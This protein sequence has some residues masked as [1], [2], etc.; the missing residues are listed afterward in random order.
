MSPGPS[1]A[2]KPLSRRERARARANPASG[3][4]SGRDPLSSEATVSGVGLMSARTK[5][6]DP[7][8]LLVPTS[9]RDRTYAIAVPGSSLPN[10]LSGHGLHPSPWAERAP[11]H[12]Y[13]SE[14]ISQYQTLP[15]GKHKT[16]VPPAR[17]RTAQATVLEEVPE[18]DESSYERSRFSRDV[19][20]HLPLPREENNSKGGMGSDWRARP[21]PLSP[22]GGA[23]RERSP[24]KNSLD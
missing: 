17:T 1:A 14:S 9:P 12:D 3:G 20:P 16:D 6:K 23:E 18:I 19:P 24:H 15:K 11:L 2:G 8:E 22:G 7:R 10:P 13:G 21:P 4:E 5:F